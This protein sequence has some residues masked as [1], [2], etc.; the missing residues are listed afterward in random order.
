[1]YIYDCFSVVPVGYVLT[2]N[3]KRVFDHNVKHLILRLCVIFSVFGK[4][5]TFSSL[6]DFDTRSHKTTSSDINMFDM[7]YD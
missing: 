3:I 4:V 7:R 5:V 2:L 6:F 1:M